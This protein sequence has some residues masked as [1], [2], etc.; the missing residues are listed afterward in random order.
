M[1]AVIGRGLRSYT[2]SIPVSESNDRI[3]SWM[4]ALA[5]TLALTDKPSSKGTHACQGSLTQ[6]VPPDSL[7]PFT[8][9]PAQGESSH[10]P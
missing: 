3:S 1:L 10:T 4:G 8:A 6:T 2:G 7:L 9:F 5:L